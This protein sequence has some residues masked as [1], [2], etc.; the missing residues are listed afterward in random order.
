MAGLFFKGVLMTHPVEMMMENKQHAICPER[1]EE[2]DAHLRENS[3]CAC[4]DDAPAKS[5]RQET[6]TV[7]ACPEC[8]C[9]IGPGETVCPECACPI[10]DTMV[11]CPDCGTSYDVLLSECPV[12][13]CP[14]DAM[15][16]DTPAV[17]SCLR[18]T[19]SDASVTRSDVGPAVAR[20]TDYAR[21]IMRTMRR[22]IMMYDNFSGRSRRSEFWTFIVFNCMVGFVL[23]LTLFGCIGRDYVY[24]TEASTTGEYWRRLLYSCVVDH[25]F[26]TVLV[27]VYVLLAFL[28]LL[29]V[30]VRRLHDTN[31][32]G[33]WVLLAVVPYVFGPLLGMSPYVGC[34]LLSVMLLLDSVPD[35]RWGRTFASN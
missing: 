8:G 23:Y 1:G 27:V 30:T 22:V 12:C 15:Q 13:A 19:A 31:R 32:S 17:A 34:A 9:P 2:N 28:P 14:N 3:E 16:T 21:S 35:N 5:E 10:G 26:M 24:V 11:V 18:Q 4:S 20:K 6:E 7:R 29:S 33:F 25:L